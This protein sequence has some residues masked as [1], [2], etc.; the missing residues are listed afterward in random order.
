MSLLPIF[1]WLVHAPEFTWVRDSKWG[2]AVVEMV[3]LVAFAGLG[4]AVLLSDLSVLGVGL[5]RRQALL[6]L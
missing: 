6:V 4:G 1:Q 2:F 3:H 5:Q